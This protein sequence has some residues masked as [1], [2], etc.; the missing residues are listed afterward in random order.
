MSTDS[1]PTFPKEEIQMASKH[2]KVARHE[3]S[4]KCKSDQSRLPFAPL[5]WLCRH[6]K[7]GEDMRTT[8][9]SHTADGK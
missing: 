5:L 9:P 7:A 1:E 6:I 3:S 8:R 2:M 4:G